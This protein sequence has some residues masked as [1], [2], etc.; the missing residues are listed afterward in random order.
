V[1]CVTPGLGDASFQQS[2]GKGERSLCGRP[3]KTSG[4]AWV[5]R[6]VDLL[7]EHDDPLAQS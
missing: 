5:A 1:L 2:G 7:N 4:D 3:P 6:R